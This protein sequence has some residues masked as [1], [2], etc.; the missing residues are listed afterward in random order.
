MAQTD[1]SLS[2][3]LLTG[4][5]VGDPE[6]LENAPTPLVR[7]ILRSWKKPLCQLTDW[8][9]GRLVAQHDGYPYV[10][11]LVWPKLRVDPLFEGAYYPGDVLSLLI[12][13]DR[14]QPIGG[15]QH[16]H[17][18][19]GLVLVDQHRNLDLAGRDRLD[20]DPAIGQRLEHRRGNAGVAAHADADDAD[21]GDLAVGDHAEIADRVLAL[22]QQR[23]A[24]ARSASGTV[25]VTSV[26]PLSLAMFWMI[27]STL[28]FAAAS[29]A[30]DRGHRAGPVGDAGQRDFRLV[31][32]GGD[33]GDQL[34]FHIQA[35]LILPILR[36]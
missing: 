26:S 34:A 15:V 28:M 20:V 7:D 2:L 19:F 29:G 17:G 31:L 10:L 33:A 16:A 30:E 5:D 21:L 6:D 23:L 27:M 13:A 11:D 1:F 24:R 36:R 3:E 4:I 35:L 8:E 12:Q 25:K 14:I 22:F 32:V 9:I 18:Q